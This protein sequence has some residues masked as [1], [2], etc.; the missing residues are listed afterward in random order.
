MKI[1]RGKV[2]RKATSVAARFTRKN[3][4]ISAVDW[5]FGVGAG[6]C[7]GLAGGLWIACRLGLGQ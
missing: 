5:M 6:I 3:T 2:R 7:I 4:L 1:P